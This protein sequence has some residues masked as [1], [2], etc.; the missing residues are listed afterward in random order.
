VRVIAGTLRGRRLLAPKGLA[1][2]PTADRVREA[3]FN[4]L[5]HRLTNRQV[6]D[7]F[8]GTGAMGIEALS[9]GAARA[10]FMDHHPLALAAIRRNLGTLR[11]AA[12][13][14]VVRWDAS[15]SLEALDRQCGLFDLIFLD[16]P[17]RS[18]LLRPT[19][20]RLRAS[21]RLHPEALAVAEH[22][23]GMGL[24][25]EGTG[26]HIIDQRTYGKTLVSFLSPV[27]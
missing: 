25:A 21:A 13:A 9:R 22:A 26:W 1:T 3:V 23:R 14:D 20:L 8:A 4:I 6:L 17:Y 16:P 12:V 5:P 18:D 24:T 2:R 10:V 19:L 11:L 27:V 7:I 15:H